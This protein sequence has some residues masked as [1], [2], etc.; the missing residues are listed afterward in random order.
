MK[1][2]P[3]I[4]MF[5]G[6]LDGDAWPDHDGELWQHNDILWLEHDKGGWNCYQYDERDGVLRFIG[7]KQSWMDLRVKR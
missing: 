7:W 2:K 6:P 5:G 1:E 3:P 4:P